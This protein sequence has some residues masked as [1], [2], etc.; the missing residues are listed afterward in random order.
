MAFH[1]DLVDINLHAVGVISDTDPGA[2]GAGKMWIDSSAG[3][4]NWVFLVR[5]QANDAWET[6]VLAIG[7]HTHTYD[8]YQ[9]DVVAN[10]DPV[11]PEV[12]FAGGE[13]VTIDIVTKRTTD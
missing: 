4:G 3:P 6:T 2:I 11:N 13:V 8:D 12:V 10:G 1:R 7:P 9:I 5:N